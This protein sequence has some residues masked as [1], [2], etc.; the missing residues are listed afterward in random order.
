MNE[1]DIQQNKVLALFSYLGFLFLIPMVVAK[2]SSFA[3][4]HVNQGIALFI[5]EAV[6]WLLTKMVGWIPLIGWLISSLCGLVV[7]GLVLYGCANVLQ[8]RMARL[9]LIGLFDIYG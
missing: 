7:L 4:F 9:P 3:R 6:L 2:E 1:N 5:L 8:G